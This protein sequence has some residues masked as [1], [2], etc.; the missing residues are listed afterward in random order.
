MRALL[1]RVADAA[2]AADRMA[3]AAVAPR[4]QQIAGPAVV[5][6]ILRSIEQD[7][8]FTGACLARPRRFLAKVGRRIADESFKAPDEEPMIVPCWSAWPAYVV[9]RAVPPVCAK[10]ITRIVS[11]GNHRRRDTLA[12]VGGE[13][14]YE[15]ESTDRSIRIVR[16]TWAGRW[17]TGVACLAFGGRWSARG[18]TCAGAL[19]AIAALAFEGMNTSSSLGDKPGENAPASLRSAIEPRLCRWPAARFPLQVGNDRKLA[20]R[21]RAQIEQRRRGSILQGPAGAWVEG[22]FP[23]AVA[24]SIAAAFFFFYGLAL[25]IPLMLPSVAL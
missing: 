15:I 16:W 20:E 11:A 1:V 19:L 7:L 18:G 10:R 5:A 22:Q 12:S 14:A 13:V 17:W 2:N 23:K 8:A 3:F 21:Q 6:D 4:R 25:T 9:W 24:I